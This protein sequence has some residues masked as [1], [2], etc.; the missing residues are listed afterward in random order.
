MLKS[1]SESWKIIGF[2]FLIFVMSILIAGCSL[3]DSST[4]D[5]TGEGSPSDSQTATIII[6]VETIPANQVGT[7][8][9]TGVPMGTVSADGTLVVADLEPGTYTT[10]QVDP[11]PD[12]DVS[13]ITCDDNDSP[14]ESMGDPAT[15]TAV[16]NLDPGE[17]VSC[18]F[19]N[20]KRGTLVINTNT[21][22]EDVEGLFQFTGVPNGTIPNNGTLVVANLQPGTYTTTQVDPEPNFDVSRVVCDDETSQTPS[23]GE[24]AARTAV[25][26]LDPGEMVTC[27]FTNTKRGTAVINIET[28]PSYIEGEFMFTGVPQGSVDSNE[29]LEVPNLTPG[30]YTSTQVDPDPEFKITEVFCDDDASST[31]S[32]GDPDTRT[33]IF[34]IDPGETVTCTFVNTAPDLPPGSG[35]SGS[36]G[37]S[38]SSG[39]GTE[40]GNGINPFNDPETYLPDFHLPDPL[41]SDAGSALVPLEGPWLATNYNGVMDCG[42][43]SMDIPANPPEAGMLEVLENGQKIIGTGMAESQGESITMMADPEINGRYNGIFDGTQEGVPV[44]IYYYWQ[45]VTE[46]NIVGYLTASFSSQGVTCEVYRPFDL[47]YNEQSQRLLKYV[48]YLYLGCYRK[49]WNQAQPDIAGEMICSP[50]TVRGYDGTNLDVHDI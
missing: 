20:T 22:P 7:F 1:N 28:D 16:I 5:S 50:N 2:I 17:T 40:P 26:N 39:E 3:I 19:T 48:K 30:T 46:E 15:R 24:S 10:T 14:N 49:K 38:E 9:Y 29:Q 41:P 13:R 36:G 43:Y 33:T 34:N 12:F 18:T 32:N 27:T 23:S 45:V 21:N 44:Q 8:S 25:Y 37:T 35:G 6:D 11:A 47:V 42:S 31:P 4:S